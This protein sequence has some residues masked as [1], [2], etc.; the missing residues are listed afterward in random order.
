[1]RAGYDPAAVRDPIY[2]AD[3]TQQRFVRLDE[4]LHARIQAGQ[5]RI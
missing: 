5:V 4:A 3:A 1:V 2:F